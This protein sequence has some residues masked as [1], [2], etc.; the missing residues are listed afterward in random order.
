MRGGRQTQY[1]SRG[2]DANA[3]H[4]DISLGISE[5]DEEDLRN[6][7]AVALAKKSEFRPAPDAD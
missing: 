7:H 4:A 2:A 3:R 5:D 6:L 1:R